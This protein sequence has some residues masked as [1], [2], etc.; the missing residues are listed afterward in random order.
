MGDFNHRQVWMAMIVVISLPL[1]SCA[2]T[3]PKITQP[4]NRI[5]Y[6]I[7]HEFNKMTSQ[8]KYQEFVEREL[9]SGFTEGD[10]VN[11]MSSNE[12]ECERDKFNGI[13]YCRYIDFKFAPSGPGLFDAYNAVSYFC[14]WA[15]PPSDHPT[16]KFRQAGA[17]SVSEFPINRNDLVLT[18]NLPGCR[19]LLRQEH[20]VER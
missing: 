17:S 4:N 16:V 2:K 7:A 13:M 9:G 5:Q 11:Y 6:F 20:G 14:F 10:F 12:A 1:L 3:P 15:L 8:S 19:V 18:R